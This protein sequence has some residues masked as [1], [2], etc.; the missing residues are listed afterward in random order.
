MQ[1]VTKKLVTKRPPVSIRDIHRG[2]VKGRST[3]TE[4]SII[5][6]ISSER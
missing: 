5:D 4:Q 3:N 6:T 2:H 1:N